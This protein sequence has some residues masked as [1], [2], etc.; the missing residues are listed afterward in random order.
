MQ[1]K[2]VGDEV[3]SRE[4]APDLGDEVIETHSFDECPELEGWS[5]FARSSERG[6]LDVVLRA[7][8][9]VVKMLVFLFPTYVATLGFILATGRGPV[10]TAERAGFLL[11]FVLWATAYALALVAQMPWRWK[12]ALH[13]APGTLRAAYLR[14]VLRKRQVV[15]WAMGCLLAGVLGAGI[16][17]VR[18]PMRF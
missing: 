1:P 11:P 9:S 8:E 10:D 18:M 14:L 5:D 12:D 3:R 2:D 16:V 15:F 6:G 17:V 13:G 4:A 7:A